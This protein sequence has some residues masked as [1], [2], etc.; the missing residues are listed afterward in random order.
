M[1]RIIGVIAVLVLGFGLSAC[2]DSP[3]SPTPAP[4]PVRFTAALSPANEVPPVTNENAGASGA[5]TITFNLTRDAAGTILSGTVDFNVTLSGF[6]NGSALTAA[7]IHPGAAGTNGGVLINTTITAGEITFPTGS[8]T[9][10]KT[11]ITLTAEQANGIIANPA[12]YY[13]NAHTATS[14]GGAVRGQLVRQ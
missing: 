12:G 5:A 8:G 3:D 10:N 13:F 7:H 14:P 2:G 4:A 1:K 11:G 6:P 9:L